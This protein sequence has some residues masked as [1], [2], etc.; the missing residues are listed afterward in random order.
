MFVLSTVFSDA[1]LNY[2]FLELAIAYIRIE[3]YMGGFVRV[4]PYSR[5]ARE[6]MYVRTLLSFT[7]LHIRVPHDVLCGNENCFGPHYKYVCFWYAYRLVGFVVYILY[8]T[9]HKRIDLHICI[10]LGWWNKTVLHRS[11]YALAL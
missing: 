3:Y 5:R 1:C 11:I 4:C 6:Q 9:W 7:L 10:C 2:E 8:H